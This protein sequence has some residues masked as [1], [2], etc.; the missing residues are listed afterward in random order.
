MLPVFDAHLHIFDPG[1]PI[2]ASDQGYRPPTFTVDAYRHAVADRVS[3]GVVVGGAIVSA[4]FQ[5]LDQSYLLDALQRLGPQWVGV[6]QLPPSV[7]DDE[8]RRLDAAGVRAVRFNLH[9]G[10]SA[11]LEVLEPMAHRIFDMLG[12]HV[13]LY[14]DGRQLPDLWP[15]LTSLPRISIDHLGLFAEGLPTLLRLVERGAYVKA[16]GFGRLDF[17]PAV[18]MRAIADVDPRRLMFGTDLPSTR[19]ARPFMSSDL[20]QVIETLG[21]TTAKRV[22]FDNALELYRPRAVCSEV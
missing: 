4:S 21:E 3:D 15:R 11:G 19:A 2:V 8:L 17:D 18:A 5:K 10:G 14:V 13:E 22:L 20:G 9:R 1:F 7:S 12:W 6:T 16:T